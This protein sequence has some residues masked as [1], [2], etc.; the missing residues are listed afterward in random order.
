MVSLDEDTFVQGRF[1]QS[2]SCV[3]IKNVLTHT[4]TMDSE[5][6]FTVA[7]PHRC[8][9]NM[10]SDQVDTAT[11][12]S[13]NLDLL[14]SI[15]SGSMSSLTADRNEDRKLKS[16]LKRSRMGM[17]KKLAHRV[18]CNSLGELRDPTHRYSLTFRLADRR[19]NVRKI[20]KYFQIMILRLL[21]YWYFRLLLTIF[22]SSNC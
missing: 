17:S 15:M 18:E 7:T 10:S 2:S 6:D 21:I 13:E 1:Q 12:S 3:V 19:W 9:T 4:N 16:N 20:P 8:W 11:K 22:D 5:D 14:K